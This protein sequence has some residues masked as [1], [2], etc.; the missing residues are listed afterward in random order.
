MDKKQRE[1]VENQKRNI[2]IQK[3]KYEAELKGRIAASVYSN[4][5]Q[6]VDMC[7]DKCRDEECFKNCVYKN[8]SSFKI[9]LSV[10]YANIVRY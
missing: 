2:E 7:R 3:K 6:A 5:N 4:V 8:D 10:Q 9:G 1:I